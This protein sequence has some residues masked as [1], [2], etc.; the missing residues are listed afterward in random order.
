MN[1]IE[2]VM[3]AAKVPSFSS[4]EELLHPLVRGVA[5]KCNGAKIEVV[6]DN[7]LIVS[8]PSMSDTKPIALSAHLD[9]INHF[10]TDQTDELHINRENEKLTGLLDDATGVGILLY[11]LEHYETAKFPPLYFLFSE[12]EESTGLK[13]TPHLLKNNGEGRFH[14]MGAQRLASHLLKTYRMPEIVVTIDT[15]PFFKG[16]PGVALYS[17]H[18]ELNG[19]NP[20]VELIEKTYIIE[21][22]FTKKYP[23]V[24][25]RNNTNDYLEYG[26]A[27]N[28][29]NTSAIPS[30][31][32]EPA[33]FPYHCADEGVFEKDIEAVTEITIDFLTS[34]PFYA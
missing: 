8:V 7:N 24:A 33:I 12:M 26:K 19:M 14:G 32:I 10:G 20:S 6:A 25:H 31:A 22:W 29:N 21:E 16:A 15:T 1:A 3:E 30:I 18:W 34:F 28:E 17:K 23:S 5:E 11:L 4:Y 13:Q 2:W 9:K 27:L